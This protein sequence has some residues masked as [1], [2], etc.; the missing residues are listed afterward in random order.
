MRR[1]R[2]RKEEQRRQHP[3]ALLNRV[4]SAFSQEVTGFV[5]RS[6][7]VHRG[8][9]AEES[10]QLPD[11]GSWISEN[12]GLVKGLAQERMPHGQGEAKLA[13]AQIAVLNPANT[14]AQP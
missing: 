5:Y 6:V 11:L 4:R 7:G 9:L 13:L 12:A 1:A 8:L 10:G 14:G 2:A 3:E